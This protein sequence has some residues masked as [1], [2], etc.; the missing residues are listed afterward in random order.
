MSSI[1]KEKNSGG[2]SHHH[3]RLC[4]F[5][6]HG[7]IHKLWRRKGYSTYEFVLANAAVLFRLDSNGKYMLT[8]DTRKKKSFSLAIYQKH[9]YLYSL[10]PGGP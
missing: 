1:A 8:R 9:S 2:A 10:I 4:S 3:L 6:L 5:S 7:M